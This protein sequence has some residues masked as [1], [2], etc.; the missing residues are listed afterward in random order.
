MKEKEEVQE[1]ALQPE[2][3]EDEN[4][5]ISKRKRGGRIPFRIDTGGKK[6]NLQFA[7]CAQKRWRKSPGKDSVA[8]P[9]AAKSENESR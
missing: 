2:E 5:K 6:H 4:E 1:D 9:N 3:K 8:S 7:V